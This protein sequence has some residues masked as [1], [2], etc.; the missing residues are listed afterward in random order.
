MTYLLYIAF[1]NS[2]PPQQIYGFRTVVACEQAAGQVKAVDNRVRST[3]CLNV[4]AR[5]MHWKGK[6][7]K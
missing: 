6:P 4:D 1:I 2:T 3:V 5:E 7:L